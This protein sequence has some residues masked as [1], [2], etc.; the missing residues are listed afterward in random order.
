M[1]DA[2]DPVTLTRLGSMLAQLLE[3]VHIAPLDEPGRTRLRDVHTRALAELRDRLPTELRGELD[4]ITQPPI[5]GRPASEAELRIMQAQ[6]VGW[7]E[8]LF[9]G[10]AFADA[11]GHGHTPQAGAV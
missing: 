6:L 10:A 9:A 8:G 11:L 1:S 5:P 3:E 4:R 7:L 2:G